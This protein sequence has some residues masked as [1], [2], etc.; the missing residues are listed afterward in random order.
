MRPGEAEQRHQAVERHG[1]RDESRR[2]QRGEQGQVGPSPFEELG[3]LHR[4]E[5]KDQRARPEGELLPADD[6]ALPIRRREP[7]PAAGA[8][9]EHGRGDRDDAGHPE[10]MI[11]EDEDHIGEGDRQRRLGEPARAQ[12]RR[13]GRRPA[14]DIADGETAAELAREGE[15]AVERARR[16]VAGQHRDGQRVNRDRRG[17][18][19]QALALDQ[20]REP[21][22]RADVAEDRTTATGSVVAMIAPRIRQARTP[23][24]DGPQGKPDDEGADDHA[25]DRQ[26][27]DRR[28]LVA[29]LAHIDVERRLEQQRRQKNI[30]ERLG[31]E[32]EIVE[33]AYDIADDLPG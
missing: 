16:P 28:D 8:D 32:P 26:K 2:D 6:E 30:E 10:I 7:A 5:Q 1:P 23:T 19:E 15:D 31:A 17:V 29:E 27:E 20:G 9:G 21:A 33:P 22:R 12:S 4:R 24:G 3:R 13:T 14:G 25:D 18:V 11:A